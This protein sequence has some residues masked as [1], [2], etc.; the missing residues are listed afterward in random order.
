MGFEDS[1]K[2]P[3]NYVE[4]YDL[5][6]DGLAIPVVR[7]LDEHVLEPVLQA[8]GVGLGLAAE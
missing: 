3:D 2:L 4:A 8:S 1:Y 7:H 6:A 5:M